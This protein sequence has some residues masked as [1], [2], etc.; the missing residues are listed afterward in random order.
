MSACV[1]V[2]THIHTHMMGGRVRAQVRQDASMLK[3]GSLQLQH[4]ELLPTMKCLEP[5]LLKLNNGLENLVF[6]M[7][8]S[9]PLFKAVG[10][11]CLHKDRPHACQPEDCCHSL[12]KTRPQGIW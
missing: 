8:F 2:C 3:S 5:P 1:R 12:A 9:R 6:G 4:F 10:I 7:L 11:I